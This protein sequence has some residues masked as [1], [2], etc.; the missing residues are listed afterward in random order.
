VVKTSLEKKDLSRFFGKGEGKQEKPEGA[1]E[2]T[3]QMEQLNI[4][5]PRS[6]Y[7]KIKLKA[8]ESDKK[9]HE[10]VGDI[11]TRAIEPEAQK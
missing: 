2:P 3:E 4:K 8:I 6:L 7:K 5:I 10:F 1:Q 9:L 11:L